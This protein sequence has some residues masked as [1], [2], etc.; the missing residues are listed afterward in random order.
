VLLPRFLVKCDKGALNPCNGPDVTDAFGIDDA[1]C[2]AVGAKQFA[3]AYRFSRSRLPEYL[4]KKEQGG[5]EASISF[6][7]ISRF[8]EN[9]F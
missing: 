5:S 7:I 4:N 3:S 2:E 1:S 9:I 6:A 8:I